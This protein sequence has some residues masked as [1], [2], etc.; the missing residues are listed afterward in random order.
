MGKPLNRSKLAHSANTAIQSV[1]ALLIALM[2][3][4]TFNDVWRL[5]KSAGGAG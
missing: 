1:G 5:I 2:L 4:A 3:L